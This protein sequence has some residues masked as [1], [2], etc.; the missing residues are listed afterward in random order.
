MD[1]EKELYNEGEKPLQNLVGAYSNTSIFRTMA[2]VGDSLSSGE[3][4]YVD[5]NGVTQYPDFYEYS[6][7]QFIARK[8][9]LKAYN[10]S[11]GGMTSK[12]FLDSFAEQKGYWDKDLACQ[13]YVIALGCN[14]LKNNEFPFGNFETDVDVNNWHNNNFETYLG[15]YATIISRYKEVSPNAKFFLV[16]FPNTEQ[17]RDGRTQKMVDAMYTFAEKFS[18][19]YVIDLY[20][21]GPVYDEKFRKHF[22]LRG[23]LNPSGYLLTAKLVDSYIDYII[24]HNPKDFK[25]VGFINSGIDYDFSKQEK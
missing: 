4:E 3:F 24:R 15:C 20:K 1:W 17:N 10:F 7:G 8:N 23:H 25:S 18:N 12:W 2:F 21:Y 5:K 13:A 22:Y 19:T 16:T 11:R 6:W 14:D 9:G